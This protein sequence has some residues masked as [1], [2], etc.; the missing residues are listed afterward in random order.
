MATH[1]SILAWRIPG[2]REPGGLRSMGSHRVGHDW[3]DLAAAAA[4]AS[5]WG[6]SVSLH[7]REEKKETA[8]ENWSVRIRADTKT[9]DS[10]LSMLSMFSYCAKNPLTV[11]SLPVP[12]A[13]FPFYLLWPDELFP[14]S[15]WVPALQLPLN[16]WLISQHFLRADVLKEQSCYPIPDTISRRLPDWTQ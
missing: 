4:A 6:N 8:G 15:C 7:F 11:L 14:D 2:T 12:F 1:S 10:W 16:T 9:Q 5:R 13:S 3:S